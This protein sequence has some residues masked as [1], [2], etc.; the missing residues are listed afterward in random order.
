[1]A[2]F[3]T[4]DKAE[5]LKSQIAIHIIRRLVLPGEAVREG[6]KHWHL[7]KSLRLYYNLR[8]IFSTHFSIIY[9]LSKYSFRTCQLGFVCKSWILRGW[10]LLFHPLLKF[11]AVIDLLIKIQLRPTCTPCKKQNKKKNAASHSIPFTLSSPSSL[12]SPLFS[13]ASFV[14]WFH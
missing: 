3:K 7:S 1:M 5:S 10:S 11:L 4:V 8:V 12:K 2:S 13:H 14:R 6:Q 9:W